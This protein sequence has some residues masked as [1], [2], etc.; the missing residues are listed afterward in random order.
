MEKAKNIMLAVLTVLLACSFFYNVHL[1]NNGKMLYRD[2]VRTIWIDTIPYYQPV[3]KDCTIIKYITDVLPTVSDTCN[4]RDN[5]IPDSCNHEGIFVSDSVKVSI[6][7]TSKMYEDSTYRAY[8]SGYRANLD[9]IF[10]FPKREAIMITKQEKCKRWGIGV[11]VGCG[12]TLDAKPQFS[13]YIGVGVSYN[14]FN[15]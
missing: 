8:V 5:H 7:I 6:P 11:Q 13:P 9:S 12:F 3:P 15:F 4:N 10:I 2:T 14:L 1:L